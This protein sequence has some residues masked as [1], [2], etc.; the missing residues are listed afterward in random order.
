MEKSIYM[1][2]E[3]GGRIGFCELNESQ[4]KLLEDSFKAKDLNEDLDE[5][6][7]DGMDT[8]AEGVFNF[9][10][11]GS[12]G[13]EGKI[14]FSEEIDVI[15]PKLLANGKFKDGIY[16]VIMRLSKCSIEFEF[17]LNDDYK[18]EK[19]EEISVPVIL[20]KQIKHEL[21]GHQASNII[22]GFNYEGE[23]IEEYEGEI[24][25]RGFDDQFIFFAIKEGKTEI[26]YSN[27][28]GNEYWIDD[29]NFMN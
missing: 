7:Y 17:S 26:I 21:Y 5:L 11:E 3:P 22:I 4:I 10:S 13:N 14:I 28:D 25:D 29:Y 19:F 8:E 24:E 16:G 20:P 1:K 12:L 23:Y 27:N 18:K 15:G 9:G 2:T 6:K